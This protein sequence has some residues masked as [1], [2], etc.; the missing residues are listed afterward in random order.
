[1]KIK[2]TTARRTLV[3]LIASIG[4]AGAATPSFA[5]SQSDYPAMMGDTAPATARVPE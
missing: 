1:M 2:S 5:D 4:L 3:A